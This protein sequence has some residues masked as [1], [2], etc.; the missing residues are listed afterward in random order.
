MNN[1]IMLFNRSGLYF[2]MKLPSV[3]AGL[4]PSVVVII[5]P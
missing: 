1:I 4:Y 2:Q 5:K 3:A